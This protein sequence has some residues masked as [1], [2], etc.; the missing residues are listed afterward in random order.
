MDSELSFR[1]S[2]R[3]PRSFGAVIRFALSRGVAV[4][5]IPIAEPW[6][7]GMIEKFNDTYQLRFLKVYTFESLEKLSQQEQSFIDFHNQ[8]HLYSSQQHKTP[9]EVKASQMPPILYKEWGAFTQP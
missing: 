1:G 3:Y 6:R 5:F 2:N 9:N 7:N 8:N 4:I